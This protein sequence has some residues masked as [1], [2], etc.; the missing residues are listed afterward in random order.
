MEFNDF[1]TF[2]TELYDGDKEFDVKLTDRY[3]F[4]L[5]VHA[6]MAGSYRGFW[7]SEKTLIGTPYEMRSNCM[8]STFSTINEFYIFMEDRNLLTDFKFKIEEAILSNV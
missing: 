8:D 4:H 1:G 7:I 6:S 2:T 3:S 5:G